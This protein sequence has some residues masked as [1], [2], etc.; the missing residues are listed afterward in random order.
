MKQD[1]ST[2]PLIDEIFDEV[3]WSFVFTTL[4]LSQ[5]CWQIKMHELCKEIKMIICRYGNFQFEVMPFGLKNSRARFQ[6]IIENVL[7][8]ESIV[9][10]YVDDVIVRSASMEEHMKHL[11]K[12]MSLLRKHRLR[13]RLRKCF[14]I[15]PKV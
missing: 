7:A 14:L 8:Y 9:K 10:C 12:V 13:V 15:Q 3:K 2:L 4:D 5:G 11:M 6:R 1:K